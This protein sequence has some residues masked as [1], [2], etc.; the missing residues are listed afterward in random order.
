MMKYNLYK[1]NDRI[2]GWDT[3]PSPGDLVGITHDMVSAVAIVQGKEITHDGAKYK[4][5][6]VN[7]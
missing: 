3:K 6:I 2:K 1:N 7:G 5:V 4:L